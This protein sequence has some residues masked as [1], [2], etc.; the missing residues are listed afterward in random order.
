MY[1]VPAGLLDDDD[2]VEVSKHI[3]V[4][5]RAKWDEI[6]DDLEQFEGYP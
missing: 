5:S 2:G 1:W 4:E 3:F 6:S